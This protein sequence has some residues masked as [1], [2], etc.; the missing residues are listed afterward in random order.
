MTDRLGFF[1]FHDLP[2]GEYVLAVGRIGYAPHEKVITLG[3][4]AVA[5]LDLELAEQP[6]A[7]E[8]V[9]VDGFDRHRVRFQQSAGGSVHEIDRAQ[10]RSIPGVAEADP[11]RTLD[12]LP[13]VTSVSEVGASLNVRGGSADQNLVLLDGVPIYNPFHSLGLFSVF[14]AGMVRRTEL[15]SGGFPRSMEGGPRPCFSSRAI[16]ETGSSAPMPR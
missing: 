16:W 13:G 2:P 15:R 3:S 6:V 5:Q 10:L 8:E 9:Q 14:S 1:A 11:M 4:G 12:A 7:L